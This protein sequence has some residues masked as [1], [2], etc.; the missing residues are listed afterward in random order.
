[1]HSL[2]SPN[3]SAKIRM[4]SGTVSDFKRCVG[5]QSELFEE[6]SYFQSVEEWPSLPFTARIERYVCFLQAGLLC[7]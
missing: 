5:A 7:L 4:V 2:P 1:M 3:Q 6:A